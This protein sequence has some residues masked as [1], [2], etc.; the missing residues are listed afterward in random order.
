MSTNKKVGTRAPQCS[1][2]R[3]EGNRV[4][5]AIPYAR[6]CVAEFKSG[7]DQINKWLFL[8]ESHMNDQVTR[9]RQ[10]TQANA[11]TLVY[12][13]SLL[14]DGANKKGDFFVYYDG[15]TLPNTSLSWSEECNAQP[16]IAAAR[17]QKRLS[18]LTPAEL[19]LWAR[20]K[21]YSD[22]IKGH[23]GQLIGWLGKSTQPTGRIAMRKEYSFYGASE[24]VIDRFRKDVYTLLDGFEATLAI[25]TDDDSDGYAEVVFDILV[26]DGMSPADF[27]AVLKKY[28]PPYEDL[29]SAAEDSQDEDPENCDC[30]DCRDCEDD[31]EDDEDDFDSDD[32]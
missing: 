12:K 31:D 16:N 20:H 1:S 14:M 13:L 10:Q 4:G 22:G 23:Y 11:G 21:T 29:V 3:G 8:C 19:A 28:V 18:V 7:T 24:A 5:G 26:P 27:E 9:R 15:S 32:D 17:G 2:C 25:T 30:A 6:Y